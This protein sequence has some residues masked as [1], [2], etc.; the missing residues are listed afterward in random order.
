VILSRFDL[1]PAALTACALAALLWGRLRLGHGL[2]GAGIVTKV[3]PGVLVP[4]A[5]AYAWRTRGRREGLICL[6]VAVAVVG[7]VVLPFAAL[8]PHGV[9]RSFERQL[10][11][12]LQIESVGAALVVAS[13]HLL[14][15]GVAMIS[16][17]G[18]Q[19]I[20]GTT[21]KVVGV[22][23]SLAQIAAL[24]AIWVVF[25]RRGR[26]RE[27]L[28][29]YAA[30]AVV[31]FVAFGKVLSPQYM[32][33]LIAVIPLVR[34]WSAWVLYVAAL[35]LTQAWFPQKY[36]SYALGFSESVTWLVLARDLVLLALLVVLL[37]PAPRRRLRP[38]VSG[39]ARAP[40][41]AGASAPRPA[42]SSRA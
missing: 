2:L 13:H 22:M 36:W 15:T 12:P 31:A 37:A 10:S 28:V 18:S 9:W 26:S 29:Q 30:A 17:S 23:Q 4:L 5:V 35:A 8:A 6:G 39:A 3:W 25:A 41:A 40:A 1:W 7:L 14:G 16:S 20:A 24:V 38:A 19:N 11:R 33:W 34:R 27:E 32:I 21:G 42:S